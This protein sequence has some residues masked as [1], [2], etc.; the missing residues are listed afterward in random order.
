MATKKTTSKKAPTKKASPKK[1]SST[2]KASSVRSFHVA[3]PD[4]PFWTF[5]FTTQSFYWVLIGASVL[6][7]GIYVATLQIRINSLYDQIDMNS[8][9]SQ[10]NESDQ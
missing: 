4:R 10:V 6:A 7:V 5:L 9:Q 1:R 8:A 2:S 3:P